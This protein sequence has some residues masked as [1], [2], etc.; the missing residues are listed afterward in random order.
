MRDIAEEIKSLPGFNGMDDVHLASQ[1]IGRWPSGAP[2]NRTPEKDNPALGANSLANNHFQYDSDTEPLKLAGAPPDPY[3][4]A[5]ADPAGATCPWAAHIRKVNTR[6]SASD[7]GGRESTYNRR[8]LRVGVPF[9]KALEDR[10]GSP[11]A[12]LEKGN[13]GLLFLS[14]Q[15]SIEQ[16]FEFLMSRWVNDP[17]RPKMPGGH[18]MIIGQNAPAEDGIRRCS[19]F[20]SGLQQTQLST[21]QQWV[22]PR[23][24][25]I[26]SCPPLARSGI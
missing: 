8:L 15:A 7:M 4:Q 16:Q 12:D 21:D 13:R 5:K 19:L 6:D 26:F 25:D 10:Y 18:D 9:G 14:I 24:A 20:G 2:V 22:I 3:A 11:D 23:V 17:S 1:L